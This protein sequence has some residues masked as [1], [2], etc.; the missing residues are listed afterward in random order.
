MF[1]L[2]CT[3]PALP[4]AKPQPIPLRCMKVPPLPV[5]PNRAVVYARTA[6]R[7]VGVLETQYNSVL[8]AAREDG[9][10]VVDAAI[11]HRPGSSLRKPGLLRLLKVI[12]KGEA[13]VLYV[14]DLSRLHGSPFWLYLLFCWMQDHNAK[15]L[16]WP[17][18]SAIPYIMTCTLS[19]NSLSVPPERGGMC[20]GSFE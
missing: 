9:C 1:N 19:K 11:E 14:Q 7:H 10:I 5:T 18:T 20:H 12:R 8:A 2:F 16:R 17:V 3:L 13:N 6:D 15:M 4:A